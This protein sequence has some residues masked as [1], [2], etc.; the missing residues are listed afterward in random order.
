MCQGGK[1]LPVFQPP[2]INL[3]SF[4]VEQ[5]CGTPFIDYMGKNIARQQFITFVVYIYWLSIYSGVRMEKI[6][7]LWAYLHSF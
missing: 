5:V 6:G 1:S 2:G 3:T 4:I 7:T